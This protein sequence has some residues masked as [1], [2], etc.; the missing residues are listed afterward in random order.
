[1]ENRREGKERTDED[2]KGRREEG[3]SRRGSK[4]EEE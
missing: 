4:L 3:K 1:M 2:R